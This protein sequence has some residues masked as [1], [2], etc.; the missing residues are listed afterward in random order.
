MKQVCF[1]G[2]QESRP[3]LRFP[4]IHREVV[5]KFWT[6]YQE[7]WIANAL[8]RTWNG[9][10]GGI[11]WRSK[12]LLRSVYLSLCKITKYDGAASCLIITFSFMLTKYQIVW[13]E[14]ITIAFLVGFTSNKN[15][16]TLL[17]KSRNKCSQTS[18]F[19]IMADG[20]NRK[21]WIMIVLLNI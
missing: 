17:G 11:W 7:R 20:L 18:S 4:H 12:T 5:P 6:S 1:Q 2:T 13:H 8:L 21:Q 10:P 15:K 16:S 19:T 9:E 14:T 3:Q